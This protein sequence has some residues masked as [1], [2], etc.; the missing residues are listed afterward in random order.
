MQVYLKITIILLFTGQ[1]TSRSCS[2]STV[3]LVMCTY[4]LITLLENQEDLLTYNIFSIQSFQFIHFC[5]KSCSTK[6]LSISLTLLYLGRGVQKCRCFGIFSIVQ[7][8]HM[9]LLWNFPT[10]IISLLSSL[11][12]N[13]SSPKQLTF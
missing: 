12:E 13:I 8:L 9:L 10:F 1:K 7:K 4:P 5:L 3:K 2:T 6:F 11:L